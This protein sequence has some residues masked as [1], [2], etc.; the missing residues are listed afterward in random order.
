M[1]S[2]LRR[3]A[4][5]VAAAGLLTAAFA[6]AAVLGGQAALPSPDSSTVS[7]ADNVAG[8]A[9]NLLLS[10]RRLL[11]ESSAPTCPTMP[12]AISKS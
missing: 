4:G 5:R 10:L 11:S 1:T 3:T 2:P 8:E 6:G 9:L 7:C 12:V